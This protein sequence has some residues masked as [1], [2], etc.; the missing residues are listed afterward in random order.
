MSITPVHKI[1]SFPDDI[2]YSSLENSTCRC[3]GAGIF[4]ALRFIIPEWRKVLFH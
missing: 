4:L 2:P 1:C 3:L